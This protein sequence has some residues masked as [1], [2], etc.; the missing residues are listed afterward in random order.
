MLLLVVMIASLM[1][2]IPI[3]MELLRNSRKQVQLQA[4]TDAQALNVARAGLTDAVA[5][6]RRQTTQ[7][8]KNTTYPDQAFTPLFA[9]GD[10][11][12]QAIGLVKEYPLGE[13]TSLY[14]RYEIVRQSSTTAF[15]KHAVHDISA[16]R[17]DTAVAGD[18]LAWLVES[19]GYVYRRRNPAVAYNVPPNQIVG[20]A[21][22]ATEIRRVSI[23]PDAPAAVVI[24]ERRGGQVNNNCQVLGGSNGY[25]AVY[26]VLGNANPNNWSA[27]TRTVG[28]LG[29]VVD[30]AAGYGTAMSQSKVF[31]VSD[32]ELRMMADYN[33]SSVSELPA[34]YPS[35]ALVYINGNATFNSSRD[36]RGGG[37]LVVNGNLT[38]AANTNM[39]FSGVIFVTGHI[40]ING[41]AYV[42]GTVFATGELTVNQGSETSVIQYDPDIITSLQQDVGQYRE[43]KG[44]YH[45]FS[46][47]KS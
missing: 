5:W 18:G 10:T 6:F 14:A 13:S 43:N 46:A 29:N 35:M 2:F 31:G 19:A 36:L 33:V 39:L 20:R 42:S 28:G 8:V 22:V 45:V 34:S 30:L 25:G 17:V 47:M 16:R 40:V 9:T 24:N 11:E 3:G 15:D 23:N 7:P 26:Y 4:N 32:Y 1:A 38:V 27:G 41:P 21:R 44:T 37:I 12:D